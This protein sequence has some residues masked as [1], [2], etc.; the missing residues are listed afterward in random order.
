MIRGVFYVQD[1]RYAAVPW[2]A[3]SG[4]VQDERYAAVPWMARSG[5]VQDERVDCVLLTHGLRVM[6][7]F[8]AA[9]D[10]VC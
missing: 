3:R 8:E 10:I 7:R 5:D 4:D 2:M 6:S 9:H 1:E